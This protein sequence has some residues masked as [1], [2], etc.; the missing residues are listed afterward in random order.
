MNA[1]HANA[2]LKTDV[3]CASLTYGRRPR[4]ERPGARAVAC[5]MLP[6]C[7][8]ATARSKLGQTQLID[9][10]DMHGQRRRDAG[11]ANTIF[12]Q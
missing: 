4:H 2:R 8:P 11:T 5:S 3:S 12:T 9:F 1:V 6:C 10:F 7:P